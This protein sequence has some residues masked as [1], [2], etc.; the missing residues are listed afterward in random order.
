MGKIS[1]HHIKQAEVYTR[2]IYERDHS[3]HDWDHIQ[4]VRKTALFLCQENPKADKAAIE[5]IALLH[6][7]GD[8]KIHNSSELGKKALQL[9]I[10]HLS[11]N[12]ESKQELRDAIH[13]IS[14]NGGHEK[15]L[16]SIEAS[17]V[18]D[19]DRLDAMGAIGVAR[20][21]VY[22]GHK[23]TKMFDDQSSFRTAMTEAEYRLQPSTPIHHFYEKLFKLKD[24]MVTEEGKKLAQERHQFMEAFVSQF[25]K[26]WN[27]QS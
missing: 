5:L 20:A 4:R 16:P 24:L 13:S 21:F 23:G 18:R 26:E 17:Y 12:S 3:G 15:K 8:P 25:L 14:F 19:A 27:G 11:L 7:I 22:S 6:D 2:P 10:D 9:A 1:S